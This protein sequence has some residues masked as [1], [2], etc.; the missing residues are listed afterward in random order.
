MAAGCRWVPR[1]HSRARLRWQGLPVTR[2]FLVDGCNSQCQAEL[3]RQVDTPTQV[4]FVSITFTKASHPRA[5][6]I[7]AARKSSV[8]CHSQHL[9]R[10]T[11]LAPDPACWVLSLGLGLECSLIVISARQLF[12]HIAPRN[13]EASLDPFLCPQAPSMGPDTEEVLR[14]SLLNK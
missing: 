9:R 4:S 11:F 10:Y 5:P 14:N 8:H 1:D 7:S 3:H 12:H 13:V 2:S 6:N